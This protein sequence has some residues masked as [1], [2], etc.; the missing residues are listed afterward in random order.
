MNSIQEKTRQWLRLD[1]LLVFLLASGIMYQN[2][3]FLHSTDMNAHIWF[4][5]DFFKTH[6]LPFP[7][8][9]YLSVAAFSKLLPFQDSLELAATIILG[10][11]ILYKYQLS[12]RYLG[13]ENLATQKNKHLVGWILVALMLFFPV[14]VPG[15]DKG[16]WYMGKFTPTIWHNSTIIAVF[17]FCII[18]F[19]TSLRWLASYEKK[20]WYRMLMLAILIALIKPSFLFAFIPAFPL[21]TLIQEKS[22]NRNVVSSIILAG[23][24]FFVIIGMTTLLFLPIGTE[25]YIKSYA[26]ESRIILA[27]FEVWRAFAKH[28][29]TA[30]V[31]SFAFPMTVLL[32]YKKRIVSDTPLLFTVSLGFFSLFV[33]LLFAESG[34]RMLHGNLYWQIPISY[35]LFLLVV[36]KNE[37][38][39]YKNNKFTLTFKNPQSMLFV[40]F[41]MHGFFG[42]LYLF[43]YMIFD[44]YS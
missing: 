15:I 31:T 42:L 29:I 34:V 12:K 43:K 5:E 44:T 3:F 6:I 40:F 11:S 25:K 24:L 14:Y 7:P 19:T 9:Y 38:D 32:I 35:F 21:V 27:P 28:K 36:V 26:N 22:W 41:L 10:F 20:Y 1:N 16:L 2:I 4:V 33:F 39:G 37:L 8:L 23:L 30:L 13:I 17:P 18:L